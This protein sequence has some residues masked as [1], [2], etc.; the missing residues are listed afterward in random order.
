MDDVVRKT[1]KMLSGGLK[2]MTDVLN[3]RVLPLL[4]QHHD[5]LEVNK[6][7]LVSHDEDILSLY[8]IH[9]MMTHV[10]VRAQVEGVFDGVDSQDEDAVMDV[11]TRLVALQDEYLATLSVSFFLSKL[12]QDLAEEGLDT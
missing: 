4:R 2:Q 11:H 10:M 6:R 7:R 3:E 8:E 1:L 12:G 5:Q 9:E